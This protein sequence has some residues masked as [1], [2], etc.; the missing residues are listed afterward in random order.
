MLP[1]LRSEPLLVLG[2]ALVALGSPGDQAAGVATLARLWPSRADET[3]AGLR[4]YTALRALAAGRPGRAAE[5]AR[6]ISFA[7][8]LRLVRRHSPVVALHLW[9]TVD[10]RIH[11]ARESPLLTH[12]AVSGAARRAP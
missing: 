6:G 9:K 11:T 1:E 7:P 12:A 4:A 2:R 8:A 5:A 10:S 3:A